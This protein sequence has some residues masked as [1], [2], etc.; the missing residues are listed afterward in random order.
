MTQATLSRDIRDSGSDRLTAPISVRRRRAAPVSASAALQRALAEYAM[1][2]TAQQLIV[3]KT[4][5]QAQ[6]LALPR[7]RPAE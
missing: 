3:V 1:G 7:S 6:P 2:S 4:G 5:A